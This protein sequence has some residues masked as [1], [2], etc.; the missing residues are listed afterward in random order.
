MLNRYKL[1]IWYCCRLQPTDEGY[2]K[3]IERF[4]EPIQRYLNLNPI[5]GELMLMSGGELNVQTI[6]IRL[7]KGHPDKYFE[8][9]RMFVYRKPEGQFNPIEPGCDYKILSVLPMHTFTEILARK[10][11]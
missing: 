5:S 7:P 10:L 11:V 4:R 3:D 6:T 8:G 1:P 9:D 2:V